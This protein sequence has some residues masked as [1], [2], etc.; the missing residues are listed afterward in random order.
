ME[1]ATDGGSF[2]IIRNVKGPGEKSRIPRRTSTAENL[3]H[4]KWLDKVAAT[5]LWHV[6]SHSV[7]PACARAS[8]GKERDDVFSF[9]QNGA[10]RAG[11]GAKE[12]ER[13]RK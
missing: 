4:L 8:A 9:A 5:C 7:Q 1:L 10:C 2:G 11:E 6:V 13:G 3:A 12:E